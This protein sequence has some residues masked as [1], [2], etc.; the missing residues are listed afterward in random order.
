MSDLE[1]DVVVVGSVNTD[2]TITGPRL[3]TAGA[4]IQGSA[5]RTD[6]GGKGANQ[7]LAVAR[8][9]ARAALIA[10]V[11]KDERALVSIQQLERAGVDT[12]A[13]LRDGQASTGAALVMLAESGEKQILT[14]P[15]A[16]DKLVTSD[17]L[18]AGDLLAH[19]KVVL[20]QLEVPMATV[21]AAARLGR[22]AGAWVVL[23]A[24]PAAPLSEE[25]LRDLHVVRANCGEAEVLTGVR[26]QDEASA[27]H[28][29]Q[30]L[31]RRGAGAA[32][33]A[34]PT[35]N[36]LLSPEVQLW[37]PHVPVRAIDATGAGDAFAA[38]LA[39]ALA[40]G[41]SLAD[42]ARLGHAAAAL[43]TT[44]PG[45]QAGLPLRA[46]VLALLERINR[47]GSWRG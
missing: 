21:E 19:A 9:G 5:F 34:A 8:L 11:G 3:P 13:V 45:A 1:F 46:E 40:E 39:V 38:G 15:G 17:V 10:R 4:T 31:L 24:G 22:A 20:L 37:L 44:K 36:M 25:L 41:Q 30:N 35:G 14:A 47:D 6:P 12:C 16:N 28:A 42:A 32:C 23:D 2:Y 27:R 33:I 7:A 18:A 26:V 43:K 29:G